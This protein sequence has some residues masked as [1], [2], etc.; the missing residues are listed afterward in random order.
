MKKLI[1]ISVLFLFYSLLLQAKP[2]LSN[3]L[4][5]KALTLVLDDTK[6]KE[7]QIFVKHFVELYKSVPISEQQSL[8]I[9]ET[10]TGKLNKI[11]VY[12]SENKVYEFYVLP[13]DTYLY[14]A[15]QE[16]I[17]RLPGRQD[18]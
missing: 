4:V 2:N 10:P 7:G 9:T 1:L 11:Q 12:L 18:I 6:S 16:T 13:R 8:F 14:A 5:R 15:A 3:D 17:K